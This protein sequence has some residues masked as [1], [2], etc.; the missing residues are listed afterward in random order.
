MG[1]N[2]IEKKPSHVIGTNRPV[3]I[4]KYPAG[5]DK[6]NEGSVEEIENAGVMSEGSHPAKKRGFFARI[7][8]H[9]KRWWCY[10]ALGGVIFLA[11]ALPIL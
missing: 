9:Y 10:Y 6:A 4:N 8:S 7:W 11:I 1:R 3:F 5:K 2:S